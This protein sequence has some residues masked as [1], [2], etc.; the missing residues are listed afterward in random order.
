MKRSIRS[1][2]GLAM[3]GI[4]PDGVKKVELEY[5][6]YGKVKD[7]KDLSK[8]QLI[9]KQEQWL[10]PVEN[11]VNGKARIR[12]IDNTRAILTTKL[13]PEG[14]L[15]CEEVECAISTDM[16]QHLKKM[17]IG[18]YQKTRYIFDIPDSDGLVWEIDVFKN[19]LGED[20]DWVKIDLEVTDPNTKL[21][22]LPI[23]FLEVIT[24]Q[25]KEQTDDEKVTIAGLWEK[26]W[27]SMDAGQK[28]GE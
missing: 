23:P 20:H 17:A 4:G 9:E 27:V 3:E 2:I 24:H 10:L 7:L 16:F 8:A 25:S 12:L 11:N 18:G 13:K 5:T 22:D 15:G 1:K 6:F 28:L 21:P 26:E 14:M 19:S